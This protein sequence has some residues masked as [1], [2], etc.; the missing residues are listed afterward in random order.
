M[1]KLVE[2]ILLITIICIA[3]IFA[4]TTALYVTNVIAQPQDLQNVDSSAV[5]LA[6][7]AVLFVICSAFLLYYNFSDKENVK[8]ILLTSN[9]CS[10]TTAN[11]NVV[12][13]IVKGC[14]ANYNNVKLRKIKLKLDDKNALTLVLHV[15]A[16][17]K[18][19]SQTLE[20]IRILLVD[21][22][23]KML[24][25]TFASIDFVITKLTQKFVPVPQAEN[26]DDMPLGYTETEVLAKQIQ[27]Q[28][29][30]NSSQPDND[31]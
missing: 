8:Q 10:S 1:R 11:K 28:E 9:C 4:I 15:V 17:T 2:K 23:A 24:N 19:V 16:E 7:L 5:V 18:D 20:K 27:S 25:L 26:G 12:N 31:Q 13:N 6:I 29:E 14:F 30:D 21:S 3:T 22:F